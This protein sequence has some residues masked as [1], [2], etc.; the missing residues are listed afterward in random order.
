MFS[1]LKKS[2]ILILVATASA[3]NLLPNWNLLP[4]S[5]SFFTKLREFVT[6]FKKLLVTQRSKM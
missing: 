2:L 6:K 5:G 3:I 4:N 1:F